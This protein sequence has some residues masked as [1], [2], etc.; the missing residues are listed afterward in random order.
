MATRNANN[1][2]AFGTDNFGAPISM[3]SIDGGADISAETNPGEAMEAIVETLQMKG[4]VIAIGAT[5]AD[6]AFRV[7]IENSAWTAADIQVAIRAL[8]ATVGANSY[9]AT[10][11]TAAD[12]TF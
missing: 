5:A 1:T 6:G 10:G 2:I 12:F 7:A 4:T 3:F 11:A 9:D 8:G